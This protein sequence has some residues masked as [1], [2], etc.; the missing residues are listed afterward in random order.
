MGAGDTLS[1]VDDDE[2]ESMLL[3]EEEEWHEQHDE[4]LREIE[5]KKRRNLKLG[6]VPKRRKRKRK[7]HSADN[8]ADAALNFIREKN[9]SKK[10]NLK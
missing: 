4:A 9:M 8:A 5:E 6:K 3:N 7:D 2:L 10:I 1:D